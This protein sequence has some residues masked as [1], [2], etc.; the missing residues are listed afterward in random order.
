M[1]AFL[2]LTYM[3]GLGRA[4]AFTWILSTPFTVT[5]FT[6]IGDLG[7]SERFYSPDKNWK[8]LSKLLSFV[9]VNAVLDINAC[10]RLNLMAPEIK[11]YIWGYWILKNKQTKKPTK[12][13]SHY[14]CLFLCL[15]CDYEVFIFMKSRATITTVKRNGYEFDCQGI[16]PHS[17]FFN[18][19]KMFLLYLFIK[20]LKPWMMKHRLQEGA[21]RRYH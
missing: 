10:Q 7:F 16:S 5:H 18:I 20:V 19:M 8:K 3:S 15:F 13:F 6:L 4:I 9:C 14:T 21:W 11:G 12:I 1:F 2:K 17:L